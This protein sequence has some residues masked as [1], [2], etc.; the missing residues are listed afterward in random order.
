[1]AQYQRRGAEVDLK[2]ARYSAERNV[3]ITVG[4]RAAGKSKAAYGAKP[5][6]AAAEVV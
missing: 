6:E 3:Q 1:M 4:E 5:R 2:E